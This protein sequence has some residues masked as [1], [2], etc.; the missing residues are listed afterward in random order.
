[1]NLLSKL[2]TI[3]F[4]A[5]SFSFAAEQQRAE[6]IVDE[7]LYKDEDVLSA[8]RKYAIQVEKNFNFK[9]DIKSFPAA[10]VLDQSSLSTTPR[11]KQQSTA[12]ELKAA[13]KES[14]Q[15][16]TKGPLAGVILLGNLPFANME[17]FARESDGRA[18]YPGDGKIVGYQV[19][20]VDFY[21]MDLDGK[22]TD[23]LV[24][25][26]CVSDGACSGELEYGENGIY[27]SHYNHFDGKLAGEDFEIW[28][29]RVNPYGEARD[30]NNSK[31]IEQ[32]RKYDTEYFP[33]VKE[34]ALRWLDKAYRAQ[35]SKAPRSDKALFTY[36]DPSPIYNED[37][38]VVSHISDL[39][40]MYNEVD[41]VHSTDK[42]KKIKYS[43]MDY[44]WLT[45]LG[46]GNEK[47]F[48]DG[49]SVLDFDT[50]V[51]R[52]PNLL[53][54]FSCN[55]ARYATPDGRSYDRTVGH[56]YLFRSL[57]GGLTMIASTKMGGGYQ[58][59]DTLYKH[60]RSNYMGEAYLKWANYRSLVFEAAKNAKDIYTWYYGTTLFGD[61]FIKIENDMTNVKPDSTPQNIA[62]HALKDLN[63]SGKCYDSTEEK[64]GFCNAVCGSTEWNYCAGIH[65]S[66]AIGNVYTKGGVIL[67][68]EISAKKAM[69]YRNYE[70]A[71]IFISAKADYDYVAYTNPKRWNK[72][73]DAHESLGEFPDASCTESVTVNDNYTLVDG[74]C[75]KSLSVS[76]T[77]TLTI[78]KGVFYV[79]TLTMASGSEYNIDNNGYASQL[80]VKKGFSWNS[81]LTNSN[82]KD[83]LQKAATFKLYVY[84]DSKLMDVNAPFYGSIEAPNTVLNIYTTAYGSY[85]GNSLAVHE[86]AVVHYEP[87]SPKI[88]S[89]TIA[90]PLEKTILAGTKMISLDRNTI[91]FEASK[92]GNYKIALMDILGQTVA[93]FN[94]NAST[95]RNTIPSNLANLKSDRYIV[96]IK[97]GNT[98]ESSKMILLR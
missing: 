51:N 18:G 61:P 15:D 17:F 3:L 69:I 84:D 9:I 93:S 75:L 24:G 50:P 68:A 67:N 57:E 2:C 73:L 88:G 47:S 11:F 62:L 16:K 29:S 14:W 95:G 7:D 55:I 37:D 30:L 83:I 26:G 41:V 76:S 74:K 63:I 94:V 4:A 12:E 90:I 56:A 48:A 80:H 96:S 42:N 25:T 35:A 34:L 6:I 53:N 71:I 64:D 72:E 59:V 31:W 60:L 81:K 86:D 82:T 28:V 89:A 77:G 27:D 1:M 58:A 10:L 70:D 38:G 97:R 39:S 65:G 19:W 54:L 21:Y 46:H 8:V 23:E 49:L 43:E 92:A 36:S 52:V 98:V 78:P 33:K 32:L 5:G 85:V 87:Y 91:V 66:A 22:W 20:A 45:H 44:D 13:I 40:K 79:G